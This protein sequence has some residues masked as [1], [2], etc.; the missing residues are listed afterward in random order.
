MMPAS[1]F[2][3]VVVGDDADATVERVA[4]AIQRQQRF[5]R[6]VRGAR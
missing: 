5:A 1:R 6:H 3:A 4:A 2:D